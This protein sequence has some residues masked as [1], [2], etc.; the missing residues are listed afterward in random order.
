MVL[1]VLTPLNIVPVREEVKVDLE[2]I[3]VLVVQETTLLTEALTPNLPLKTSMNVRLC[4]LA[5]ATVRLSLTTQQNKI[6]LPLLN[7]VKNW[8]MLAP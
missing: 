7:I 1:M 2:N 6:G 5:S 8:K 3:L 4:L